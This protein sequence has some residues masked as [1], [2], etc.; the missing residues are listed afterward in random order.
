MAAAANTTAGAQADLPMRK[1][2]R[3]S[4][5]PLSSSKRAS[6]D[7]LLHTFKKKGQFDDLRKNTFAQFD[8]G[9]RLFQI[10][11]RFTTSDKHPQAPQIHP[12][13][14]HSL[15]HRRRDRSRPHQIPYQ[16]PTHRRSS[17]RR[18]CRPRRHLSQNRSRH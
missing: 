14:L 3:V 5:L 7:S 15:L 8:Q 6:I 12:C 17:S 9:V 1:R 2:P 10:L 16:E 13:R 11:P 18:R 4:D